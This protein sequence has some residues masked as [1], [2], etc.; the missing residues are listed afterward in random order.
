MQSE[1]RQV[2]LGTLSWTLG[3]FVISYLKWLIFGLQAH[4]LKM[5]GHTKFQLSITLELSEL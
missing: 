3:N 2:G 5:F 1:E 4:F